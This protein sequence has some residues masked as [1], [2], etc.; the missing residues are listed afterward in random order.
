[1]I[2]S[3]CHWGSPT[4]W[5][6]CHHIRSV[7]VMVGG[8][9]TSAR[10][11]R[12]HVRSVASCR[13][14]W[15]EKCVGHLNSVTAYW[16]PPL[17]QVLQAKPWSQHSNL[18]QAASFLKASPRLSV[19]PFEKMKTSRKKRKA[20]R[21]NSTS[22]NFVASWSRLQRS[23]TLIT[24]ID[25]VRGV[26]TI[27][28]LL[29]SKPPNLIHGSHELSHSKCHRDL[30]FITVFLSIILGGSKEELI[31]QSYI[32]RATNMPC[33]HQQHQDI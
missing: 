26:L 25:L 17:C 12:I 32:P 2:Y 30:D 13:A 27:S 33:S 31:K 28:L 14:Q 22:G 3:S 18:E 24:A 20:V 11:R 8:E 9:T 23:P 15:E 21:G 5:V 6:L 16:A 4:L 7:S 19:L 10:R 29:M 1:M